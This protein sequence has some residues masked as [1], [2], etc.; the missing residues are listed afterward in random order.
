MQERGAYGSRLGKVFG[1]ADPPTLVTRA[2]NEG[3]LAVTEIH[4]Y[5]PNHLGMTQPIPRED[6]FLVGLQFQEVPDHH[7]WEDGRKAPVTTV[8]EGQTLFY[9][10]QRNPIADLRHPYHSVHFYL[11]RAALDEIADEANA[12]RVETIAYEP[13]IPAADPVIMHIGLAVAPAFKAPQSVASL[14][15]DSMT[16]SLCAHVAQVYGGM[17]P[18]QR[19]PRG[20]LAPW[21][22]RRAKELI[23]ASID[24]D[25][26]VA[27]LAKE[28]RLSSGHFARAFRETTGVPPHRWLLKCRID[29]ARELLGDRSMGLSEVALASGFADQSHLTRVFTRVLGISPGALRRRDFDGPS[30]AMPEIPDFGAIV[31]QRAGGRSIHLA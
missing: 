12:A 31:S 25:I 20:R 3:T 7:Y 10:L 5:L 24:G 11:T 8:P 13:G 26:S 6:A 22:E 1:L 4:G 28:C 21:Q 18:R 2:M 15:V 29:H 16:R 27:R 23:R 9:D 17:H 19:A 14:F 30:T